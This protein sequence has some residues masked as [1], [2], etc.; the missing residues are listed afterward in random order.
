MSAPSEL[1]GVV[2]GHLWKHGPSTPY[3][4]RKELLQAPSSHWSGSAGA[5]YP[6]LARL[7]ERGIVR[8]RKA[9]RGDREGWRYALTARGTHRFLEWLGPPLLGEVVSIAADPL[10]TRVHFLGAL[11]RR[12]RETFFA[13][14]RA[15]LERHVEELAPPPG[16]DEFDRL[17]L[18]GA[19]RLARARI[20]WLEDVRR[21][22]AGLSRPRAGG[23]A[24]RPQSTGP[25]RTGRSRS[26][27]RVPRG[28]R[29]PA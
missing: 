2:L 4:I 12:K 19:V 26:P 11:S 14:A 15:V 5:I 6:L 13:S 16:M 23:G 1:E 29:D 10:R 3:S 7:E 9:M 27:A 21:A 24:S 25:L 17:A 18:L 8:S 20:A 22:L 28:R